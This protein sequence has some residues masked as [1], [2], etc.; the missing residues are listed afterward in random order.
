MRK[1]LIT[2]LVVTVTLTTGL[3]FGDGKNDKINPDVANANP[4]LGHPANIIALGY[5]L[6]KIAEGSDPL[7]NP[8]GVITKFG[9]LNDFP[10]QTVEAT[11]TEPDENTYLVLSHNPGGPTAGYNYGRRFLFQGHENANDL[12]YVTRVNLDVKDAAH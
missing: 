1:K 3:V 12:A 7:E 9:F 4:R 2:S 5:S 10:P 8:S 6:T 11:K